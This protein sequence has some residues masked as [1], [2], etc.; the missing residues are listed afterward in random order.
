MY[1]NDDDYSSRSFIK[2]NLIDPKYTWIIRT[3]FMEYKIFSFVKIITIV[4]K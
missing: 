3:T 1:K 2:R 4:I